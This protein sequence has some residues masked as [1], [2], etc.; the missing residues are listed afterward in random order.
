M[1]DTDR[2]IIA[3][4][5]ADGRRPYSQIAERAGHVPASSVR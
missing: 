3:A 4:L 2:Q 5:Q 1:D